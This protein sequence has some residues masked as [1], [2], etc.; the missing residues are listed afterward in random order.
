MPFYDYECGEC[1]T[2]SAW[3]SLADRNIPAQC[4]ECQDKAQR[5][6]SAPNLSLMPSAR[7]Q[8]FARN[9]KSAHEPGVSKRHRCG[10]AC[11]C[12]KSGS[13]SK[14]STRTV[15]LGKAGRFEASRKPKRPWMLGH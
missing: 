10:S 3:R 7:R 12:G 1:G 4:P 5:L 14:K 9:E 13:T 2:F 8:A 11:G 6:I 15:D